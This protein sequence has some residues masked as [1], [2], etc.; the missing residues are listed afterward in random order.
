MPVYV[1]GLWSQEERTALDGIANAGGT[2]RAVI[3]NNEN[4]VE[5]AINEILPMLRESNGHDDDLMEE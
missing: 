3:A 5:R 4:D 2:G 1:I